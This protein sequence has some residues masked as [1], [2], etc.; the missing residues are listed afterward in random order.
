MIIIHE[1][2]LDVKKSNTVMIQI[3]QYNLNTHKLVMTITSDGQAL[4]LPTS[5]YNVWFKIYV[6]GNHHYQE[7]CTIEDN[8]VI[9]TLNNAMTETPGKHLAQ[10]D[11]KKIINV[12]DPTDLHEQIS[13][14]PFYIK[15][16]NSVYPDDVIV[17]ADTF[18]ELNEKLDE[19]EGRLEEITETIEQGQADMAALVAETRATTTQLT[20]DVEDLIDEAHQAINSNILNGSATGSLRSINST[21]ESGSYTIGQ[22]AIAL[23][24]STKASGTG[25]Y[26]EGRSTRALGDYSHAEGDYTE[27]SGI[28]CH[29]EGNY[30]IA[31]GSA[32]HA[33]GYFTTASASGSH[34][35]GNK[36]TASGAYSHAEGYETEA[37]G[38]ISH[39]QNLG[40]I[41][42]S[43]NQTA[44][45][46]YN[47]KDSTNNYA[48][49][50]GNGNADNSRSNA[51]TVDWNGNVDIAGALTMNSDPLFKTQWVTTESKDV[52]ANTQTYLDAT[53]YSLTG[54][55][56]VG[57][58]AHKFSVTTGFASA[59]F[60][61]ST[62][63]SGSVWRTY[64][65]NT[66]SNATGVT[67]QLKF[68]YIKT[69]LVQAL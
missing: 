66:A 35:E 34:A 8:K 27:A 6:E 2:D 40:T 28:S 12:S 67:C 24:N 61:H 4:T 46:K 19:A 52:D 5:G 14:L 68:L 21:T 16:A 23:G 64:V 47:I 1:L 30:T 17:E 44:L 56:P 3:P 41:A 25:S 60:I 57:V 62:Y 55:T 22:N 9:F 29:S 15:V 38:V 11:F 49:I 26:A 39:A 37:S 54:Y 18:G 13:T 48:V 63:D 43:N 69:A 31:S 7:A 36:S 59:F 51:L 58:I 45:G 20:D 65:Q 50:I 42:A 53:N 33:E 32:S 10:I